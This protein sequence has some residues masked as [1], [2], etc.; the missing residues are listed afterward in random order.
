MDPGWL[1]WL[2]TGEGEPKQLGDLD[3]R[4]SEVDRTALR[5]QLKSG[6]AAAT[7]PRTTD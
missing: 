2:A 1:R 6:S 5:A 4:G 7:H 3:Q